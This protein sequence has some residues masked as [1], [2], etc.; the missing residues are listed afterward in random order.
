MTH[1]RQVDAETLTALVPPEDAVAALTQALVDGFDP[2][3]DLPRTPANTSHGQILTMP[4]EVGDYAGIKV[5]TVAPNNPDHDLPR[6]QA[7]YLLYDA[8]T[9]S[10]QATLD[11]TALTTL[12][13]P[14]VS[15]AA[16]QPAL[17]R[18]DHPLRVVVF[19]TGPQGIGHVH[20]LQACMQQPLAAVAFIA[21]NPEAV[22]E[23]ARQLGQVIGQGSDEAAA[24]LRQAD[25]IVCA[26]SA[27]T[28]VFRAADVKDNVVVIAMGTHEPDAR[29]VE[30]E[31]MAV[32][33]VLVEDRCAALREAGDVVLAIEDAAISAEELLTVAEVLR[34][35]KEL[36]AD[37]PL[38]F[39]GV[40]MPWEDLVVA[41]AA[42][43]ALDRS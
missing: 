1:V 22:P 24:A 26:T 28:P 34:G 15:V 3:T 2:A 42:L 29:E 5:V 43:A 16:V 18:F 39:K 19:G 25:V 10:L 23:A 36:P 37:K 4:S 6:I 9:L 32:A 31:L 13:T 7:S 14:A 33:T 35:E 38:V 17:K 27:R 20:T 12:R 11:G 30:S 21:R 41:Q 8:Q 40:G